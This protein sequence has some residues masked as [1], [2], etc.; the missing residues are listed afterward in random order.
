MPEHRHAIDGGDI[1]H[2]PRGFLQRL[3]E[4]PEAEKRR[5]QIERIVLAPYIGGRVMQADRP[6]GARIVDEGYNIAQRRNLGGQPCKVLRVGDI[7]GFRNEA[8]IG[9]RR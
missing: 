8:G 9:K 1:N 6:C 4:S 7:A 5:F 3:F 2:R